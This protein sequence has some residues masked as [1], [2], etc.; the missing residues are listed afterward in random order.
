MTNVIEIS[1][2]NDELAC[3]ICLC[4]T[5]DSEICCE[6]EY[7]I[8]K[9]CECRYKIH[10]K[11]IVE[12]INLSH[13]PKCLLCP[14]HIELKERVFVKIYRIICIRRLCCNRR[15]YVCFISFFIKIWFI[16][17]FVILLVN[18]MRLAKKMQ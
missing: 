11:C 7:F 3:S 4:K 1:N 17:S 12:W 14:G 10:K 18:V 9:P 8:K 13:K 16:H 15:C 5:L 2:I 6:N